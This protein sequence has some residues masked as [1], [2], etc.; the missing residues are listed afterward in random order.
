MTATPASQSNKNTCAKPSPIKA[1]TTENQAV[2]AHPAASRGQHTRTYLVHVPAQYSAK[3]AVPMVIIFHGHGG[4]AQEAEQDT[5]FSQLADKEQFIAVYPQGLPDDGQMPMWASIGPLD[6]NIDETVFMNDM[7]DKLTK[8]FCVDTQRIYATGFSN[9]GGM[10]GF[11][12]CQLSTRIA[13]VAP[14]SG[15]YYPLQAGCHP[16]RAVPMLEIHGSAD[17]IVPYNG[18]SAKVNPQWPLPAVQDWLGE[19]AKRNGCTK[20]PEQ[21]F[22]DKNATGFRWTDCHQNA[23]IMHY[24]MEGEGHTVPAKIGN[25]PTEQ[26]IWNFFKLHTL[27]GPK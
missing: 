27:A 21:F 20:G 10:S 18:I 22:Q 7:L 25:L 23:T 11:V 24:R 3:T 4:T 15:N 9:G 12:A 19:W 8:D 1:G 2:A 17:P 14:I 13:A 26:V 5:G 16:Q 6:Y